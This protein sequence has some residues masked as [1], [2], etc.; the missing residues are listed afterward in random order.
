MR[1]S[2]SACRHAKEIADT[3]TEENYY[4]VFVG[5]SAFFFVMAYL[6]FP[7]TRRKTLEEIAAA[8]GDKV[9]DIDPRAVDIE[10]HKLG[11][12][13]EYVESTEAPKR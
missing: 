2:V 4:Y 8:F 9:V 3:T 7:E 1:L 13:E 5:C 11:G 12:D 10:H 6:Y